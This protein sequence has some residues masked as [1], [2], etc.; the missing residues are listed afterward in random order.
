[1]CFRG[2]CKIIPM[3]KF[4]TCVICLEPMYKNLY[5]FECNHTFHMMCALK[6]INTNQTCPLCRNIESREN[7]LTTI[8]KQIS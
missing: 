8:L 7:I 1:M 6:W 5:I 2:K 3:D 4:N